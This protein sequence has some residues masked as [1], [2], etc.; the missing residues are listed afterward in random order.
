MLAQFG[1]FF[2]G[3]HR[4]SNQGGMG[5]IGTLALVILAPIA[6]MIVQMAISRSR[7]YVADNEGARICGRPISLASAL[8]KIDNAAHRIPNAEAEHN[9]A[10]AHMFIINPLSGRGFDNLFTTHPSTENRIAALRELGRELGVRAADARPGHAPQGP[11]N[12]SPASRG[13]WG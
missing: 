1:M 7:E 11:W 5:I 8:A 2:G 12:R 6:A 13:P 9:P 3:G 4:D 10:T